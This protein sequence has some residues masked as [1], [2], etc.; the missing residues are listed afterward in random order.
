VLVYL[1]DLLRLALNVYMILIIVRAIIS[2]VS[3]DPY[4]PLV[5]FLRR[6]TD[7]VLIPVRRRVPDMGGLDISPMVVLLAIYLVEILV[8]PVLYRIASSIG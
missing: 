3:P 5:R 7:P 1:V 2:W 4:N 8:F 6:V